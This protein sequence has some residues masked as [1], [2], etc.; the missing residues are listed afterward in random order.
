MSTIWKFPLILVDE[1]RVPMPAGA[2]ILSVQ[3]QS[4]EVSHGFAVMLWAFVSPSA[5]A[6]TRVIRI[7][8]TGNPASGCENLPFIG[9][10][11]THEGRYVWH[12]FDGGEVA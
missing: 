12:V 11:Q 9:T 2:R 1:N 4:D 8:G 10:V 3:V 5:S 7:V 6:V